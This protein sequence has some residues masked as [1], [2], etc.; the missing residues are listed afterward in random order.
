MISDH[1]IVSPSA[2]LDNDVEIGP[3]TIV[4]ENVRI[5]RGTVI[6]SHC[7]LGVP[8]PDGD[9]TELLIGRNS[10]I[11]SHNV[12]YTGSEFGPRLETGHH[13]TIR[14]ATRAGENL[15]VGTYS[16]IQGDATIGDF[17]RLHSNVFV[18]KLSRIG[19]FVW[20]F[21]HVVLTNDPHPPS[22]GHVGVTIEPFAVI[23]A[24]ACVGPG[25]R[26]GRRAVVGAASMVTKDVADG[27]LVIGVPARSIGAA[28]RVL[29][30]DGS[31]RPAYPWT[32]HFKRGYP[33]EVVRLWS[34]DG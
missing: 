5:E 18:A 20:L 17:V 8:G 7:A 34:R 23:S 2:T 13:V 31:R 11:R 33:D 14:E 10:I 15:R 32:T 28:A 1:A 26:V 30:R 21:P 6:G 29:L 22:D 24:Q 27:E 4:H 25:V 19:D 9:H 12:I 16:D 3:F